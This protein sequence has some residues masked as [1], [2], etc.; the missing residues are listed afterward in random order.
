MT[1]T[2]FPQLRV[3]TSYYRR[4]SWSTIADTLS[5]IERL[6]ND[7]LYDAAVE[8]WSGNPFA[9]YHHDRGYA[10]MFNGG[11]FQSFCLDLLPEEYDGSWDNSVAAYD[12]R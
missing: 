9:D 8:L 12:L 7:A 6:A 1:T 2:A 10:T 4:R 11:R 5:P 3:R